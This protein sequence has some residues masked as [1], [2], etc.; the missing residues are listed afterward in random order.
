[1]KKGRGKD[2]KPPLFL[3]STAIAR[4]LYGKNKKR[5]QDHPEVKVL[6]KAGRN[7][8]CISF[9]VCMGPPAPPRGKEPST[10]QHP[11]KD[12]EATVFL[13]KSEWLTLPHKSY[14]YK[15][16]SFGHLRIKC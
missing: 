3:P 6:G 1:M 10:P 14:I 8:S 2:P 15:D 12:P 5:S 4:D 16:K 7:Q 9:P 11:W 13:Q